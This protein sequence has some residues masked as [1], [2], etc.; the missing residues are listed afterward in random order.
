MAPAFVVFYL[1][2]GL[3]IERNR[4]VNRFTGYLF[5]ALAFIAS[6]HHIFA[7]FPIGRDLSIALGIIS[8]SV[9]TIAGFVYKIRSHSSLYPEV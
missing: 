1:L 9:I 8:T 6:F 5:L 2:I 4:L 7:R 3:I